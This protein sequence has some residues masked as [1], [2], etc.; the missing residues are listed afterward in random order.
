MTKPQIW[1][2]AFLL[3]FIV[4][5]M[6]GRLTKE[7]EQMKDFSAM[8]N[9]PMTGQETNTELTGDKLFQSFGCIR[10]HGTNLAGTNQG[11]SLAGI[12]EFWS[13]DN[14]INYL[15]NPN[16][17]M[18]SDRFKVYRAKY[19]SGIMPSFGNKDVKDLGRIA[20]YLLTQ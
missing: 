13:R 9:S 3:L 7:E 12:K 4:L 14:L 19:P 15:R 20:D 10:C 16:S 18:D 2:A 8:N 6:I 1:V 5:F 11:P 17:F